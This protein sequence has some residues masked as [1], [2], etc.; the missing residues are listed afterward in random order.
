MYIKQVRCFSVEVLH[1]EQ[2]QL[3]LLIYNVNQHTLNSRLHQTIWT[4][5]QQLQVVQPAQTHSIT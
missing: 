3:T 1:H 5:Y 4:Q 2:V